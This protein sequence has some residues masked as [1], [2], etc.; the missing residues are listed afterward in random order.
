MRDFHAL[1]LPQRSFSVLLLLLLFLQDFLLAN[2]RRD[3]EKKK[4]K[5]ESFSFSRRR[6]LIAAAPL[7]N[8]YVKGLRARV[9]VRTGWISREKGE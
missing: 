8:T 6:A 3:R 2:G 9:W 7:Y 5:Q 1:T 4:K